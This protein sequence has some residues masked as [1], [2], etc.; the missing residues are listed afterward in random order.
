MF[1]STA[2]LSGLDLHYILGS[3][4]YSFLG[5]I[6]MILFLFLMDKILKLEFRKELIEDQNVAIGIMIAGV[7]IGLSIIIASAIHG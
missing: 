5:L 4:V 2:Q 3:V 1:V 7:C 6:L